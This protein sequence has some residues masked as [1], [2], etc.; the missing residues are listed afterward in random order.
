MVD[1]AGP[2][3]VSPVVPKWRRPPEHLKTPDLHELLG[4]IAL[5]STRSLTPD[6]AKPGP[7]DSNPS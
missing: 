7:R 1:W 6:L 5:A 3:P 2:G 4:P